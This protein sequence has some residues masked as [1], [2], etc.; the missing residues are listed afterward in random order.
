ME[1]Q[2]VQQSQ[3]S[4]GGQGPPPGGG[5]SGLVVEPSR[6]MLSSAR[7]ACTARPFPPRCLPSQPGASGYYGRQERQE[8]GRSCQITRLA[9][10]GAHCSKPAPSLPP[11]Q[12]A[13][14]RKMLRF[15]VDFGRFQALCNAESPSARVTFCEVSI[16]KRLRRQKR[17]RQG[18]KGTGCL[19]SGESSRAVLTL[20]LPEFKAAV[21]KAVLQSPFGKRKKTS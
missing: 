10:P 21:L 8:A 19:P 12:R 4:P 1:R 18:P 7:R 14:C 5:R 3:K 9:G 13:C 11:R 2:E 16:T 20:G 15:N 6:R 17:K